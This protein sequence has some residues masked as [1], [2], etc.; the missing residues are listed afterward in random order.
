MSKIMN[1][2]CIKSIASYLCDRCNLVEVDM[3][4]D[5]VNILKASGGNI[6]VKECEDVSNNEIVLTV[7]DGDDGYSHTLRV[8]RLEL[9]G[10]QIF[11]VGDLDGDAGT[12]WLADSIEDYYWCL[13]F[14][15]A[16]G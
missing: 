6:S 15:I 16:H 5:L 2:N 12:Y 14:I 1:K 7:C 9:E 4:N 10:D 11:M 8:R 13:Q 3:R